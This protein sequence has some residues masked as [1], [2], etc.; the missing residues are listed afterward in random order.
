MGTVRGIKSG[1]Q[2]DNLIDT[3]LLFNFELQQHHQ[4]QTFAKAAV[5]QIDRMMMMMQSVKSMC[6]ELQKPNVLRRKGRA[7]GIELP[8]G[9]GCN[10]EGGGCGA[11]AQAD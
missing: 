7:R 11:C 9:S 5:A 4:P 10:G 2:P 8:K 3:K 1:I 6:V